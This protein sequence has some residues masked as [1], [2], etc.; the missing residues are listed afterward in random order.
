MSYYIRW[1][2]RRSRSLERNSC[3]V[4]TVNKCHFKRILFEIISYSYRKLV[5]PGDLRSYGG[6][7]GLPRGV[8]QSPEISRIVEEEEEEYQ[9][10]EEEDEEKKPDVSIILVNI[11]LLRKTFPFESAFI[12]LASTNFDTIDH[13]NIKE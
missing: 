11:I 6:G 4:T 1:Y 10:E 9:E 13:S 8:K 3:H 12:H 7:N 2:S 5:V